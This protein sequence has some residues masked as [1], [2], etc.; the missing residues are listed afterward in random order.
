MSKIFS[1]LGSMLA[2]NKEN[3]NTTNVSKTHES[4]QDDSNCVEM[5]DGK[6]RYPK[7]SK[8]ELDNSHSCTSPVTKKQQIQEPSMAPIVVFDMPTPLQTKEQIRQ[9]LIDNNL[10]IHIKQF[11]L[12]KNNNLIIFPFDM[13][14]KQ[15]LMDDKAV[16]H[17]SCK[18]VDLGTKDTRPAVFLRGA[19]YEFCDESYEIL[20]D[21]GVCELEKIESKLSGKSL[22]VVKAYM[23]TSIARDILINKKYIYI[24]MEKIFVEE[25]NRRPLQ[26]F[27]CK[28]FGHHGSGCQEPSVCYLC[29]ESHDANEE[30]K[31]PT[32]CVNCNGDHSSLYRKCPIYQE[33]FRKLNS[34]SQSNETQEPIVVN[35]SKNTTSY[36]AIL[37]KNDDLDKRIEIQRQ[38]NAKAFKEQSMQLSEVN[39]T[40]KSLVDTLAALTN[41]VDSFESKIDNKITSNNIN[42]KDFVIDA[43]KIANNTKELTTDKLVAIEKSFV[44]NNLSATSGIQSNSSQAKKLNVQSRNSINNNAK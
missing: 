1:T 19:S 37:K 28:R 9:F 42:I 34:F 15:A 14:A 7:R 26:C 23:N 27:K 17:E 12:N 21:L 31:K 22:N 30:C 29:Q 5:S 44:K 39:S 40:L 8:D 13:K 41:K 4:S 6:T 20:S 3:H 33:L 2:S 18:I 24:N 38:E 25:I 35:Q 32:T 10:N 43:I 11:K 16:F 36:S